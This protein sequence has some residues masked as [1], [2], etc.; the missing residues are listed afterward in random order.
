[1]AEPI[2]KIGVVDTRQMKAS[3]IILDL[4]V[5]SA[6]YKTPSFVAQKGPIVNRGSP[7]IENGRKSQRKRIRPLT[8]MSRIKIFFM[9][10]LDNSMSRIDVQNPKINAD[11]LEHTAISMEN[12]PTTTI[13]ILGS[14]L[15]ITE[16]PS[17]S[18]LSNIFLNLSIKKPREEISFKNIAP[19]ASN[20]G[21]MP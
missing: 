15:W 12:A 8:R 6:E 9:G 20:L 13:F 3:R 7:S 11:Q 17:V 2:V 21:F 19:V 14:R 1:M 10:N 18:V 4:R 16:F 5:K